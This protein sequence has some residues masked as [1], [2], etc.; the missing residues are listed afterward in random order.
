[1]AEVVLI[2]SYPAPRDTIRGAAI[3]DDRKSM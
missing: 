2:N 1:M 3:M